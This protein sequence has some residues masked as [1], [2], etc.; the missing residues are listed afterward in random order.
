MYTVYKN[1]KI[2]SEGFDEQF[3]D[4]NEVAKY[5]QETKNQRCICVVFI[6]QYGNIWNT[7]SK[8]PKLD[9]QDKISIALQQIDRALLD[10]DCTRG[11]KLQTLAMNYIFRSCYALSMQRNALSRKVN[12]DTEISTSYEVFTEQGIDWSEENKQQEYFEYIDWI[13]SL[14]LNENQKKYCYIVGLNPNKVRDADIAREL[15]ISQ[16]AVCQ[17]KRKLKNI[18]KPHLS[19]II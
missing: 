2:M 8:F 13:N 10:F 14:N 18:L 7:T 4:L 19:Y 1:F 15:N 5:Y 6:N 11:T 17:M 9:V 16:S 3:K 12:Y